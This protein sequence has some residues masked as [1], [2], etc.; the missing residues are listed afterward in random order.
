MTLAAIPIAIFTNMVRI[1]GT[2]F[3]TH[4]Y[5]AEAAMGFFHEF[6]GLVVFGTA[7]VMLFV[8][9]LVLQRASSWL[10]ARAG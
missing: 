9:G 10:G 4:H 2:A 5:G 8:L 7:L 6:A 1:V 3:L